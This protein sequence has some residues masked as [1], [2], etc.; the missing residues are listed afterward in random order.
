M[1]ISSIGAPRPPKRVK[2]TIEYD[3]D[4]GEHRHA[5]EYGGAFDEPVQMNLSVDSGATDVECTQGDDTKRAVG[6]QW[7]GPRVLQL[8][9]IAASRGG[10]VLFPKPVREHDPRSLTCPLANG[11]IH[12]KKCTCAQVKP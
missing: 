2:V 10:Q 7:T 11:L 5:F 12:N 6:V 3:D 4:E 8:T 1:N 9:V